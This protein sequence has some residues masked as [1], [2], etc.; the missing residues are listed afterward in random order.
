VELEEWVEDKGD[1]PRPTPS[2]TVP[3]PTPEGTTA[4]ANNSSINQVLATGG[5]RFIDDPVWPTIHDHP[6]IQDPASR[7]LGLRQG[8]GRAPCGEIMPALRGW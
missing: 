8:C 4:D 6:A 7:R 5:S 2:R 1:D 3:H